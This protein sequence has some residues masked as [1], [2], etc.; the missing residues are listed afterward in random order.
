M[1]DDSIFK[2]EMKHELHQLLNWWMRN[3]LD[4]EN[5]GFYGRIDGHGTLHPTADKSVILNT[6]ILWTFAAAAR[7]TGQADYKTIA[8]RAWNY[9]Q[10]HFIDSLHGG[11][12]LMLNQ[13]GEPIQTK[14]QIYAQAFALYAFS[15]YHL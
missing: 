4:E 6:R 14:K 1:I 7:Q 11:V 9:I 15:E 2:N 10:K 13:H 12:F 8:G 5:G 3:M